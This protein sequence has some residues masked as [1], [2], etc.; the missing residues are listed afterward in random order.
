M[1]IDR[2]QCLATATAAALG[3]LLVSRPSSLL[4]QAAPP[5]VSKFDLGG[6]EL[7]V[8]VDGIMDV[9]SSGAGSNRP[10]A[11]VEAAL[12]SA[13]LP[14]KR[15]RQPVNV[16]VLK[17]ATDLIVFDCGGG[18]NFMDGLGKFSD[19]FSATGLDPAAVTKVIFTHG[20]PDH[21]WGAVDE[22]DDSLR[23]PKATYHMADVELDL[24]RS[25]DATS[26]L[27][28]DRANFVTGAQR[29]IK[30][31]GDRLTAFKAGAEV[32]PGVLAVPTYG[33]TQGHTS[34]ELKTK[35]G[36]LVILG[37]ALIHPLI[38]FAHPDWR[39]G[40]DH[41][42]EQAV[43]T[44]KRLLDRLATDKARVLG[45]HLPTPGLGRVERKDGAYRFVSA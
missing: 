37:D 44:R 1:S 6:A 5:A 42:P 15:I 35:D 23:F 27:P 4:A 38:S 31:I 40:G 3:A 39:P 16:S 29:N 11:E 41:V 32:A 2:R 20:H 28:A 10:E 26:K 17:T 34:F 22:F 19:N 7:H 45:C 36:P 33:H 18:P 24:W 25:P 9:G 13:G 12:A 14:P 21:L 8:V 43:E 30:T